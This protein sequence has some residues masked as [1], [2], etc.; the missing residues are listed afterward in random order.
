MSVPGDSEP[1]AEPR[2]RVVLVGNGPTLR[3]GTRGAEIDGFDLVVRFNNFVVDGFAEQVGRRTDVWCPPMPSK[4][5]CRTFLSANRLV[6]QARAQCYLPFTLK[7]ETPNE[8]AS[9]NGS[10]TDKE[11]G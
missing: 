10:G 6:R 1:I 11:L 9:I 7:N 4:S 8:D 3:A 2:Q 5:R